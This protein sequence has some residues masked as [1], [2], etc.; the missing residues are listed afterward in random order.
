MLYWNNDP[1]QQVKVIKAVEPKQMLYWNKYCYLLYF[2]NNFVEPKQMLYWNLTNTKRGDI[3]T[4]RSNRNK[5]CIEMGLIVCSGELFC[6]RTETNVVLKSYHS[7][8]R[9]FLCV[10]E[11]KQML[12]WN[13]SQTLHNFFH[14]DVEP[15]QM[16][17][18]NFLFVVVLYLPWEVEPKQMLYWNWIRSYSRK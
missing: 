12:Y 7:T 3:N 14:L 11:P 15:K 8:L 13:N 5:C 17:Y 9:P 4:K 2:H 1:T 6:C 10:V 16:L 18:W